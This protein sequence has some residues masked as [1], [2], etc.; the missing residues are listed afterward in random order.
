MGRYA[1]ALYCEVAQPETPVE[2][3][4]SVYL[5]RPRMLATIGCAQAVAQIGPIKA[6]GILVW[7]LWCMVHIFFLIG[8]RNRVRVMSEWT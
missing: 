5:D 2:T 7:A 6:L 8:L 3:T 4:F 1:A